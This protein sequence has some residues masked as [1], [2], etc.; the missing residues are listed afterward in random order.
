MSSNPTKPRIASRHFR[1]TFGVAL[2][3]LALALGPSVSGTGLAEAAPEAAQARAQA[4]ASQTEVAPPRPDPGSSRSEESLVVRGIYLQQ[5]TVQD[6]KRLDELIGKAKRAG[7]NT[8]VV[9]LWRRSPR[10]ATAVETIQKA[11]LHYVPRI[12]MF[13]DGANHEQIDNRALLEKRWRLVDYALTLGAKDIQLDYIRF[14]SRNAPSAENASKVLEVIRFFR[15]RIQQRG[16]RLQI[17]VFGEVSYGPSIR[18]GQDMRLFAPEL[19][20]VCPMLYPSH[21][22]P[23][24]ETARAPYETVHGALV[25]LERQTKSHPI[26][27]YPFIEHFNYRHRMSDAERAAYFEAQLQ[28]VLSSSAQGFYVWSVGNYYDIPFEVLERRAHERGARQPLAGTALVG[29]GGA[30]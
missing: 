15:Q 17:D 19:D 7:F 14:S 26:P 5:L 25:A 11:G 8:F 2:T 13:P 16:A 12:T 9:D 24:R 4:P 30:H 6:E 10:Y 20:A 22:E 1:T 23:Y 21:F 18:I 3:T 28:A 29:A 27:L